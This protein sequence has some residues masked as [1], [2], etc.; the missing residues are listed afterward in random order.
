MKFEL[1]N[2]HMIRITKLCD[3]CLQLNSM[4]KQ[5]KASFQLNQNRII[6]VVMIHSEFESWPLWSFQMHLQNVT[7]YNLDEALKELNQIMKYAI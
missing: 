1:D 7:Y 3:K 2:Q 6:I 5:T 4:E